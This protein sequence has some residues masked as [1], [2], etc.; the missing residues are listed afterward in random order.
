VHDSKSLQHFVLLMATSVDVTVKKNGC[1][2]TVRNYRN[3]FTGV[4]K[5]KHNA[6]PVDTIES[7][8][9]L[10]RNWFFDS[11]IPNNQYIYGTLMKELDLLREKKAREYANRNHLTAYEA[12]LWQRD[13]YEYDKP[14]TRVTDWG[15]LLSNIFTSSRIG[16][17][18]ESS[19]EAAPVG[20]QNTR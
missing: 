10:S 19:V 15:L 2:E 3:A 4:W 1:V 11:T 9:N 7:V 6:I 5:Q 13:S 8:T 16:E 17:Y 12:Q 14:G 18:I 20:A